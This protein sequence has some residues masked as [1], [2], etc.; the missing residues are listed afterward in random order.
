MGAI[1]GPTIANLV[2]SKLE[3]KWIHIH[4]PLVYKRF[5][6]DILI[7][8]LYKL[9]EIE[10]QNQFSNLKI[11]ISGDLKVVFLDLVLEY[12]K[13][14]SKIRIWLHIKETHNFGYLLT[15]SNHSLHIFKNIPISQIVT[16]GLCK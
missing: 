7:I 11:N 10:F 9:N 8:L 12:D 13:V 6:D 4:R 1:C 2:V 15:S 3:E 16:R 14:F 5:I